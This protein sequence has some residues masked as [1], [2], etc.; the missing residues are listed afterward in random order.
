MKPSLPSYYVAYIS[1]CKTS[2]RMNFMQVQQEILSQCE[3]LA[4]EIPSTSKKK[5]YTGVMY[6]PS[7][8]SRKRW[9]AT[10]WPEFQTIQSDDATI[11]RRR[12]FLYSF[13]RGS[14]ENLLLPSFLGFY[15]N[16]AKATDK[17]K[18]HSHVTLPDPPKKAAVY[19]V[20]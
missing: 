8:M 19:D 11:Q 18:A 7:P 20:M 17:Q 2:H 15:A 12:M 3:S 9:N 5:K 14:Q 16:L 6:R 4:V 13:L 1:G 10:A